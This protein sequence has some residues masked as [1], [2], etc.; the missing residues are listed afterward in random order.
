MVVLGLMGAGKTTLA[1]QLARRWGRPLRDSDADLEARYGRTAAELAAQRGAAGLHELEAAQLLAA[2]SDRTA[3]GAV[4]PVVAAA[5]S[6]VERAD[7]RAALAR[8]VVVWLDLPVEVLARRQS[9]GGHRPAYRTDLVAMLREMDAARRP[10]FTAVADVVLRPQQ[11][12]GG[13]PPVAQ[14]V[15]EVE[16]RL[17]SSAAG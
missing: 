14:L 7:C 1:A 15:A 12:P 3:E 9:A 5:A 4:A 17:D 11:G 2:L 13:A 6:V 8:A 16:R 10:L